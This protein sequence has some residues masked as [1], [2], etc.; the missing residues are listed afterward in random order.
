MTFNSLNFLVFVGIF[1]PTYFLLKGQAK[2]VFM[3]AA[4]YLFYGWWDWRFL[5]L[6]VLSTTI[7]YF[8]GKRL[9]AENNNK[10]RKILLIISVVTN[11]TI[12]GT[13]KYLGFFAESFSELVQNFGITPDW[14][15]L[16]LILPIGISFYTFQSLSYT[17]DVYRNRCRPENNLLNFACYIALFP[18]LVAGPIVRATHFLPQLRKKID[19][20]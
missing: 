7:D 1:Y 4:S 12:L 11:L 13:F 5:S 16:N 14:P 8:V 9:G 6:I 2:I 17:I 19:F 3:L 18:Q 10:K 20:I 15:T